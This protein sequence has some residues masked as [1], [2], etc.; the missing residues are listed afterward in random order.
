MGS[1]SKKKCDP[2]LSFFFIKSGCLLVMHLY[3]FC[4]TRSVLEDGVEC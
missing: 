3:V 2:L 1:L 4:K